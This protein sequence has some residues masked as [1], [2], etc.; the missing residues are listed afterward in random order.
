MAAKK[1]AKKQRNKDLPEH[2]G[3]LQYRDLDLVGRRAARDI[4]A[5]HGLTLTSRAAQQAELAT[6]RSQRMQERIDSGEFDQ[7]PRLK[8]Q[9]ETAARKDA[10]S[11]HNYQYVAE[12]GVDRAITLQGATNRRVNYFLQGM[13]RAADEGVDAGDRWYFSHRQDIHAMASKHGEPTDVAIAA[14]ALMSPN[15]SPENEKAAL[16]A[17]L[18]KRHGEEYSQTDYRRS[19]SY[20][21]RNKAEAALEAGDANPM[22]PAKSPKVHSYM[23]ATQ[24]ATPEVEYEYTRRLAK[25]ADVMAGKVSVGQGQLDM[26]MGS[27]REGILNPRGNTAEDSWMNT[28]SV[29]QDVTE[30]IPTLSG[31]GGRASMG[32]AAAS[33]DMAKAKKSNAEGVSVH[34][35]PAYGGEAVIHALNN[36]ATIRAASRIGKQFGVVDEHGESLLPA[37]ALQEVAWTEVRREAGKD[38]EYNARVNQLAK[39]ERAHARAV[40]KDQGEQLSLF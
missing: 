23:R 7:D 39:E 8:K 40:K 2:G 20:T 24:G 37:V 32:K 33:D 30:Y 14:G 4:W 9:K 17:V 28:I 11:A 27:S 12:H 19:G 31:R 34:Q 3:A 1:P 29:G 18:N 26:G 16:G 5:E 36:E 22:N 25:V 21:N 35:N 38:P 6:G 13:Q 15:N 10:I